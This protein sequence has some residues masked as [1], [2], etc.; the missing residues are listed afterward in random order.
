MNTSVRRQHLVQKIRGAS[1]IEFA[2]IAPVV[3]LMG[4]GTIQVGMVMHAKSAL[5]Y[6]MQEAARQGATSGGD[7]SK[8]EDGL[9]AGL[10]P[11]RGGGSSLADMIVAK[12][13]MLAEVQLG[14]ASGWIVLQQLSPTT[15]TFAD[16]AE[17][18]QDDAGNSIKEIPNANLAYLRCTKNPVSGSG[19]TKASSA[20]AGTA[21]EPIG[22]NS[23]QTLADA[24]IL[25]LRLIYGVKVAVPLI[26]PMV[27]KTMSMIAGCSA[28]K[29]IKVGSL[30]LGTPVAASSAAPAECLFYQAV[31]L[32]GKPEPRL[33][34]SIEV[35]TRMQSALRTAGNGSSSIIGARTQSA[36]TTGP[37]LGNGTV[38][39]AS[40]FAPVAVSILNPNGVSFSSDTQKGTGDGKTAIGSNADW[41]RSGDPLSPGTD[42]ILDGAS[43]T[44]QP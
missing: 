41:S 5:N 11:F 3:L 1:L 7:I 16:W 21:G 12:A 44:Q 14:R 43:S 28:A 25:K 9:A 19:G 15:N 24:N 34:V 4:L 23:Q 31:D 36:N 33:P 27:A 37:A 18:A 13:K 10:I 35:T 38:D 32:N 6:A 17:D 30:D 29:A 39:L 20:C 8:I 26:G 40:S 42:C 2:L 22:T